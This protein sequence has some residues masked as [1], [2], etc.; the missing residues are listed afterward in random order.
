MP[1]CTRVAE[2]AVQRPRLRLEHGEV[3]GESAAAPAVLLG[4]RAAQQPESPA[5]SPDLA[6]DVVLGFPAFP[7]RH[8]LFGEELVRQVTQRRIVVRRHP[9]V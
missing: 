6:V 7:V 4:D 2:R 5:L 3:V 1:L 8:D 9:L